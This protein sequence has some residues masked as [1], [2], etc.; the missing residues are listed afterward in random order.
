[1]VEVIGIIM[2]RRNRVW[3][4]ED[5]ACCKAAVCALLFPSSR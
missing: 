2:K 1:M 5:V 3:V 4:Q